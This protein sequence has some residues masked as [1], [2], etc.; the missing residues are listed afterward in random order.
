MKKLILSILATFTTLAGASTVSLSSNAVGPTAYNNA[1][2]SII[3]NGSLIR[4]GRLSEP[5]VASSFVEFGTSTIK[6]GGIG[7]TARPGKVN[8]SVVNTG[9]E[10][11]DAAFN[12]ANVFVWIYNAPDA[13]S[14]TESGLFQA[15]GL[16]FP[17][18][19]PAGV[20]DSL[21]ITATNLT[22]Y[23]TNPAFQ[24]QGRVDPT[25]DANGNTRLVLAANIPE[26]TS[27]GLLALLGL[28]SLRRRR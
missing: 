19:D 27:V 11:D 6:N 26:P 21:S 25:S 23:V 5:G 14:S 16:T 20:G 13:G 28:A 12:N 17:V 18:D 8:G 15:V 4:I 9:G 3:A 24:A 1:N 2:T 10:S 22:V 7:P